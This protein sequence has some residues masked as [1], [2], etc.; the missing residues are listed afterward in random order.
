[1]TGIEEI[2]IH[3]LGDC[4]FYEILKNGIGD[5]FVFMKESRSVIEEEDHIF[6]TL[7]KNGHKLLIRYF[8]H[9]YP[10]N[11]YR[12]FSQTNIDAQRQTRAFDKAIHRLHKLISHDIPFSFI[13]SDETNTFLRKMRICSPA[14]YAAMKSR[15]IIDEIELYTET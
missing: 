14:M 4:E 11:Y 1:M 3:S 5:D 9:I 8:D 13:P 2:Y 10:K 7:K 12:D 15:G 6:D